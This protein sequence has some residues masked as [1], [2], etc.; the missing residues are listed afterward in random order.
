MTDPPASPPAPSTPARSRTR[1]PGRSSRPSRRPRPTP[2]T[3]SAGCA[4]GTSTRARPTR[5]GPRWRSAWPR[6]RAARRGFA[7]ASGLAAEDTLLRAIGAPGDHVVLPHDAYGGTFRLF[8]RV[9]QPWGI[10]AR[11]ASTDRP[12][13]VERPIR[14]GRDQG[15]LG[16]DADQPAARRSP[17]S[18][19]SPRS[20]TRPARCW[21]S[22]TPSPRPTCSSRSALGADVVVHSTTKYCG[23]PLRRGRRGAGRSTT[24][25]WP[26]GCVPPERDRRRWPGRSTPGSCCAGCKT[27][28]VRMERH[29]DNAE[30]VADFLAAHPRVAEV[31]YPG[32]DSPSRA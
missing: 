3:A 8:A 30:R 21:S 25:S 31:Y 1:P 14:P 6:W 9:H 16:G 10:A 24:R 18:P 28:A 27:L 20:P 13:A 17:T 2:R 23:G 5:P 29:S 12:D 11:P 26:S 7:F 19:P 32:L 22:T 4:A 15:R